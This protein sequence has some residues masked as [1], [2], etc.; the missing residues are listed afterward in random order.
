MQG[1]FDWSTD[2][3]RAGTCLIDLEVTFDPESSTRTVVGQLC[4]R[5]IERTTTWSHDG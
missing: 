3:G 1:G 4:S 5:T 2:D